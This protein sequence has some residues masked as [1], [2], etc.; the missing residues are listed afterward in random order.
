M[1]LAKPVLEGLRP[2]SSHIKAAG[3]MKKPLEE[4]HLMQRT[5]YEDKS[6]GSTLVQLKVT[7]ITTNM[8]MSS[9]M[10]QR[11]QPGVGR[12]MEIADIII[13]VGASRGSRSRMEREPQVESIVKGSKPS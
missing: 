9:T 11:H 10:L 3:D 7:R 13:T 6:M 2:L 8:A 4:R 1:A 5:A 12:R